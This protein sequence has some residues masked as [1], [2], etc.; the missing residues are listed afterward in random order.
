M[1]LQENL[2]APNYEPHIQEER[3]LQG[4]KSCIPT[5]L[6]YLS[7]G[8]A[9][10]VVEKTAG[11]S[12]AEILLMS[13]LIYA[14]SAQ[15]IAAGMLAASGSPA[16]I[17]LTIFFVNLRH[18]LLSAALSPYF[19]LLSPLKNLLVGALLTDETFGVAIHQAAMKHRLSE[20]WMHGLNL[21]AYLNWIIANIAGAFLGQWIADPEQLGLDFALP[22]MFIGL[23]VLQ[24]ISRR[25]LK[26]D[27]LVVLCSICLVVALSYLT[28]SSITIILATIAAS[29]LGMAVSRWK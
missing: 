4:V 11:L 8:F 15:F 7:I 25:K 28:S 14:G 6:G 22:A 2:T 1:A 17:V 24:L 27:L 20:K 9:A 18:L 3:F 29:T 5:L 13:V 21:T 10:G 26:A 19:R 23:L 12:I 16:A